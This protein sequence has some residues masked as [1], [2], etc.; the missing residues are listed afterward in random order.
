MV[1]NRARMGESIMT[2]TSR[3][4]VG[5]LAIFATFGLGAITGALA[6]QPHMQSALSHLQMARDELQQAS[7]D[8][9]GHRGLALKSVDSAIAHTRMG[10]QYDRNH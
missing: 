8:K 2:R 4:F 10:I 1:P 9:G 3:R 7:S 5:G 6:D